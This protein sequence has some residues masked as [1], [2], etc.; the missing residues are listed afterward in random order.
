VRENQEVNKLAARFGKEYRGTQNRK[1]R[2][3]DPPYCYCP[4]GN[5][6]TTAYDYFGR[7][8]SVTTPDSAVVTSAYSGSTSAPV[9]T[10]V[11]VTDQS[12]KARKGR[13]VAITYGS[14]SSAGTYR[15][16]DALGRVVR[17]YQ[18]TDAVNYLTEATYYLNSAM[19]TETY[20]SVPGA[21]GR[22][23]VS[24]SLDSAARLSSLSSS[25]TTYAPAA[26][27]SSIAYAPHSA[28]TTETYGNN[29]V[30]A[31]T[32]N[33]R[34]QPNQIKLGTAAAPTSVL[35]LTYNYGTTT[36][37]GNVQSMT[38]AGGGLSYTQTFGY[39]QLNR[40][41]TS[42]ENGGASWSQT[43][44]YDRYGNRSIV[45]GLLTFNAANNRIST[46]GYS[47]DASGNLTNDTIH[48]YTFDAENK[49]SKVDNVSAYVY[50]GE[51]QRVRKLL[52]ENLRFIYGI[53]G[54]LVAEFDGSTGNLKK[55]YVRGGATLVTIEPT[56][57]NS[58]GTRYTTS[59]H[60]GSPRVITNSSTGVVS[61][62]D[63]MPFGVELGIGIG[64]RT[65]GMGY[66]VADGLR[67]K[68]TSKERDNETGWD[69][70]G[71]RYF[72]SA[73]GRFTSIDPENYQAMRD[74]HDPQSWNAY[75]YV[76]NNPLG[77][78]DPDGRGFWSKLGNWLKWSIWGEE[79]DVK[80]AEETKRQIMLDLEKRNGGELIVQSP[81]SGDWVLLHP[82]TMNRANVFLWSAAISSSPGSRDLTPQ[83]AAS[84]IDSAMS[85]RPA[86]KDDP[87][88]PDNVTERQN[89]DL[90][91][92]R[93]RMQ[94]VEREAERLGFN[95][96]IAP[97]RAPF[98][99]HGQNV[100]TDGRRFITRDVDSHSGGVW[101]M[102]DRAGRRIGTYD[103]NLT[104]IGP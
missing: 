2:R 73:Q 10:V 6:T 46:A 72:S 39:D 54:Q 69:Y 86:L 19:A 84:V 58:N 34:L 101:K 57:V 102:F 43:N 103:A 40:L 13:L 91:A 81:V 90:K 55:E 37:N 66:S 9:G 23:T 70:F 94:S 51:G 67:Q 31:I 15:G 56:A 16:Y 74:L 75:V 77:R 8:T 48:A 11:T 71:A 82:A 42:V 97:Q 52:G 78:I 18:R 93:E 25:A 20:P 3:P 45:G 92:L 7:I 30:H 21:S 88:H 41:T 61:R 68:F 4:S 80:R 33:T 89:T 96:R 35:N 85:A 32:Y 99:S 5:W 64:G 87:Y 12:G 29:L 26:S 100:F 50:D 1:I 44:S 14:G 98:D 17:Q 76:N 47:Y 59:D 63:Y 62:H 104:R 28:L 36:N 83:E 79:E 60:L 22:R 95:R 65:T 53:G 24:Y 49:I 27:V 38:Y